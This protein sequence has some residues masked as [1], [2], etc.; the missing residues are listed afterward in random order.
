MPNNFTISEAAQVAV[1]LFGN[2]DGLASLVY[3]DVE[4]MF[5]GKQGATVNVRQ[6]GAVPLRT[7]GVYDNETPVVTDKVT[8]ASVPVE[9]KEHLHTVV[10]LSA[11]DLDLN[12][13]DFRD[14]VLAPQIT[15]ALKGLDKRLATIMQET[16]ATTLAYDA[17]DPGRLFS[18]ARKT[19]RDRGVGTDVPL[20]AAVGS[21]VFAD[22][23]D[24]PLSV[25]TYDDNGLVRGFTVTESTR[26][27]ADEAVFFIPEAFALAVRAPEKPEG[28]AFGESV[29]TD[30]F[31]LLYMR[32]YDSSVLGDRSIVSA[33]AG[34]KA[35]PLCVDNEDGTVTQTEHGGAVRVDTAA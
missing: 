24:A 22:L 11:G 23:E 14:R 4:A 25:R 33:F 20:H 35:L 12:I 6:P 27:A 26:L 2:Y 18:A 32:D 34:V 28:V 16:P 17:N 19:L 1:N 5:R 7:R 21:Q 8:E 10:G 3:R 31:A 13:D 29:K 30:D 15:A 9:L